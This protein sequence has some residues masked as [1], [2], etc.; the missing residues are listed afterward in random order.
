MKILYVSRSWTQH[1][2]RFVAAWAAL[3][4]DV[5]HASVD[6]IEGLGPLD[7]AS[8]RF[9]SQLAAHLRQFMPDVVHAGPLCDVAPVVANVWDGPLIAMSWGFDLMSEVEL[10]TDACCRAKRVIARADRL[11]IDNDAPRNRAIALGALPS[12]IVQFPWGV[13]IE[14]FSPGVSALRRSLGWGPHLRVVLCTR[15]HEEVYGVELVIDA[16]VIAARQSNCLR[17]I[18]AGGG[19]LTKLY[20]DLVRIAGMQDRVVFLGELDQQRLADAYRSADLYVSASHVDGTSI[21]L[22]EAMATGVPVCVSNIPGNAE[23]VNGGTGI[24]FADGAIDELTGVLQ[25]F[26]SGQLE[27]ELPRRVATAMEVVRRRANWQ[28]IIKELLQVAD[29]A[30]IENRRRS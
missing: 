2:Q 19:S 24:T 28:Q 11:V 18:L 22:L 7:A 17:L 26:A 1:D 14:I 8:P 5:D 10:D 9:G 6:S 29:A 13:D 20:K 25:K 21:S 30:I 23:W 4:A 27:G 3:G 12:R 16:F 15:R